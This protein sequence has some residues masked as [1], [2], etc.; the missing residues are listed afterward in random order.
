MSII[1]ILHD[2]AMDFY[3]QAKFSKIKGEQQ[4]HDALLK[5]AFLLEREAALKMPMQEADNYWQYMLIRSAGSLAFQC[6]EYEQALQLVYWGL[7]GE[8]PA[9]EKS[10]LENLLQELKPH[11]T[12][13]KNQKQSLATSLQ[14]YGFLSSADMDTGQIKIRSVEN[15]EYQIIKISKDIIQKTARYLI[16][17]V[18]RIDGRASEN[19]EMV[20][21]EIR[22]A[23]AYNIYFKRPK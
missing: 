9:Y 11:T 2:T 4:E 13:S 15:N 18:V 19:G 21:E 1:K 8:P 12:T 20:V 10:H 22:R 14:L 3:D 6:K 7:A 23:A 16:G 17:E 5:K